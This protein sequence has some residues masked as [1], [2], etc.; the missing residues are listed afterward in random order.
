MLWA[1]FPC[2]PSFWGSRAALGLCFTVSFPRSAHLSPFLQPNQDAD[3][4][5]S[6]QFN[7]DSIDS[8]L[9][10]ALESKGETLGVERIIIFRFVFNKNLAVVYRD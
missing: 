6:S 2:S 5:I 1:S 7:Q 8:F 3:N 10:G 4:S 9:E